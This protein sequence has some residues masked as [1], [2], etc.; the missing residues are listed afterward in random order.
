MAVRGAQGESSEESSHNQNIC[1]RIVVAS[2]SHS[3]ARGIGIM[4]ESRVEGLRGA[5]AFSEA[6]RAYQ[7]RTD[8]ITRTFVLIIGNARIA[9]VTV[10]E[11][12][13]INR[14]C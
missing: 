10:S 4:A 13:G 9:S 11:A 14:L 6:H 1:S 12:R 7:T 3:K 5:Q 8:T 2:H